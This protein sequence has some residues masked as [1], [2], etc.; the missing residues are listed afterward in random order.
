MFDFRTLIFKTIITNNSAEKRSSPYDM[1]SGPQSRFGE[2]PLKLQ[3]DCPQNGT[4]GSKGFLYRTIHN[5]PPADKRDGPWTYSSK[6][7]SGKGWG[8]MTPSRS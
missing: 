3:V 7:I 4:C 5:V 8:V 6:N 1:F 2:K